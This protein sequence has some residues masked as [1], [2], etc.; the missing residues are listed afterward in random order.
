MPAPFDEFYSRYHDRVVRFATVAYGAADADDV[1]QE[2]M[3]RAYAAYDRIDHARDA[4]P[5]LAVVARHV[6][7]DLRAT[8]RP[9]RLGH[10]VEPDTAAADV[11]DLVGERALLGSALDRLT[12]ADR[13]VLLLRECHDVPV[14]ELARQAG[15]SP[16]AL[17]QQV[18]RAKR[19]LAVAYADLGGR[20]LGLAAA[21]G[22]RRL[23]TASA[24]AATA[25]A[26]GLV[27]P[28]AAIVMAGVLGA[29]PPA[30]TAATGP[31]ARGGATAGPAV[32][33]ATPT[34]LVRGAVAAR[35]V[36]ITAR[37][38]VRT[39]PPAPAA[40]AGAATGGVPYSRGSHRQAGVAVGAKGQRVRLGSEGSSGEQ[41]W[42]LTLGGACPA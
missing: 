25:P 28:F 20:A 14:G 22:A 23:R 32:R 41:P 17:R 36:A 21:L 24:R 6:A 16:N 40:K 30:A 38:D 4:W 29:T 1:A 11:A 42:C 34:R 26:L 35:G 5:W 2:T 39:P 19:R 27:A 18:F 3:L 10:P 31:A 8:T 7:R 15:C 37:Q 13:S 33:T 9:V 12:P